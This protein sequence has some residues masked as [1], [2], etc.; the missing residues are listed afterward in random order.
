MRREIEEPLEALLHSCDRMVGDASCC[1]SGLLFSKREDQRC[2]P[3]DQPT[4]LV[5][6]CYVKID[7]FV[8]KFSG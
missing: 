4:V 2:P 3:G 6:F 5:Q 8:Q 1:P 7:Q